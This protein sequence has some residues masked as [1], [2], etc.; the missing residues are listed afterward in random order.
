MPCS[1]VGSAIVCTGRSRP[2]LCAC[3]APAPFLCDWKV[4]RK[5][6]GTCDR[7]ICEA[8]ATS[9]AEDKH[10]CPGH[11]AAWALHPLAGKTANA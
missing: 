11:A 6:S 10:L 2:A 8:C 5:R 9:P 7:K 1:H 3:G 4:P